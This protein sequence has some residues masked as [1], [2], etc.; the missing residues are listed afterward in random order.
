MRASGSI[1][2]V[3]LGAMSSEREVD[4]TRAGLP[5][6]ATGR[7]HYELHGVSLCVAGP[8][9]V[10]GLIHRRLARFRAL[11]VSDVHLEFTFVRGRISGVEPHGGGRRIYDL[12]GGPVIYEPA[13]GV[14][15]A[16]YHN[17]VEMTCDTVSGKTACVLAPDKS[18]D[19]PASEILF[20]LALIEQM[21]RRELFNIHAAGLRRGGKAV[22]LAGASGAGKSTLALALTQAGWDYLGDDMLFLRADG[23][24][25]L[26]FPQGIS[27]TRDTIRLLPG[28]PEL[29]E[30]SRKGHLWPDSVFPCKSVFAAEAASLVFPRIVQTGESVLSPMDSSQAFLELASN[31]LMSDQK[32]CEAHFRA[33]AK[34]SRLVPSFRLQTGWNLAAAVAVIRNLGESV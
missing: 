20:T 15:S 18:G 26:G 33:L 3:R 21:R 27:Y 16:R 7:T 23:R 12:D 11:E 9:D 10:T 17:R 29:P 22:L 34:L 24:T 14:M 1:P 13:T 28:L 5:E 31:V 19:R 6:A 30:G 8:R 2:I 32:T 25:L 4:V